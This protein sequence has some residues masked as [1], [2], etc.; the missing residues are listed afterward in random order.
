[1]SGVDAA[2]LYDALAD[3]LAPMLDDGALLARAVVVFEESH[4]NDGRRVGVASCD[5][6]GESLWPWDA[7]GLVEY[8]SRVGGDDLGAAGDGD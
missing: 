5:P 8:V 3:A 2:A 7:L 4:P 6:A 1:M